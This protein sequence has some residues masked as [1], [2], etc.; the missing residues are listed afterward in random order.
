L[1]IADPKNLAEMMVSLNLPVMAS[2]YRDWQNIPGWESMSLDERLS[3]LLEP[4]YYAHYNRSY[5]RR[6]KVANFPLPGACSEEIDYVSG[7]KLDKELLTRLFTCSFVEE[8]KNVIIQGATGS[9]KTYLA[10]AL[11]DSACRKL[12]NVLYFRQPELLEQLALLGPMGNRSN[13]AA[14]FN[15]FNLLIIDEWLLY[16]LNEPDLLRLFDLFTL[17]Y[18]KASTLL[19]S[20]YEVGEWLVKLGTSPLVESIIDRLIHNSYTLT[21][22]SSISMRE[23]FNKNNGDKLLR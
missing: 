21:I 19:C 14:H 16:P 18:N 10:N 23:R 11:G 4:E 7:R 20:Q 8:S 17:R 12:Y 6:L 13:I 15:K 22:G 3:C 9:G 1:K 2:I 5:D